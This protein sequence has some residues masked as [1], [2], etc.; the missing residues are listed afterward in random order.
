VGGGRTRG[1]RGDAGAGS[2]AAA[3]RTRLVV[4]AGPG[5]LR[6]T[7]ERA[8]Q[9]R[10]LSAKEEDTTLTNHKQGQSSSEALKFIPDEGRSIID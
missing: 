2:P 10:G 5:A 1:R 7:A 9:V 8:R 4:A 3:A 6:R